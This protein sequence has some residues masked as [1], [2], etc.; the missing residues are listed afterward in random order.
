MLYLEYRWVDSNCLQYCTCSISR[1]VASNSAVEQ[2]G[3]A[4][5]VICVD[6]AYMRVLIWPLLL[7]SQ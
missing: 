7:E 2:Q 1:K 3:F 4:R 5:H 6:S